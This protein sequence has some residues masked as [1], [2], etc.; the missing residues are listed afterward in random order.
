MKVS[1]LVSSLLLLVAMLVGVARVSASSSPA[2][3]PVPCNT[4]ALSAPFTGSMRFDSFDNFGCQGAWAF[5]WATV[6]LAPHEIGV[7][8]VLRFDTTAGRWRLVSRLT[9]CKPHLLP[10]V[11]YRQGCFSN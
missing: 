6:G 1:R 5:V 10:S 2:L 11:V 4:S 8:E 3:V 9:Y 7:T